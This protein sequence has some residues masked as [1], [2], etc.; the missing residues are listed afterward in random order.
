[1]RRNRA[2]AGLAWDGAIRASR[3]APTKRRVEL[4]AVLHYELVEARRGVQGE[5]RVLLACAVGCDH[6]VAEE[7]R[8][9]HASHFL[10]YF[11][12]AEA[13]VVHAHGHIGLSRVARI[14]LPRE[15]T[16]R[17]AIEG[18]MVNV[19]AALGDAIIDQVAHV[20]WMACLGEL[21]QVGLGEYPVPTPRAMRRR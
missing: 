3:K 20:L 16:K 14:G 17:E 15:E 4:L 13:R 2:G 21:G 19:K 1:M 6:S 9:D 5:F 10:E 12:S 11:T 18:E 8:R 7:R